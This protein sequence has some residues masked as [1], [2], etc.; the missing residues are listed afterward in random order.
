M[1]SAFVCF[2]IDS[3]YL[4][5]PVFRFEAITKMGFVA[6]FKLFK[7]NERVERHFAKDEILNFKE[8]RR[9][10]YLQGGAFY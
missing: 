4:L 8:I 2:L 9:I 1:F 10:R 7:L 5:T 3:T 6:T